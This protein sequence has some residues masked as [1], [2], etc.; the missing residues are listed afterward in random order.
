MADKEWDDLEE[1]DDDPEDSRLNP[2]AASYNPDYV[3]ACKDLATQT[4]GTLDVAVYGVAP[5]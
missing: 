5:P 4:D 2:E 1:Y 3:H